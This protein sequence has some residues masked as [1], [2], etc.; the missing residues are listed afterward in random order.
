MT[1]HLE[2]L[3]DILSALQNTILLQSTLL[4]KAEERERNMQAEFSRRMQSMEKEV[5][6][7]QSGIHDLVNGASFRI[8]DEAGKA[9]RPLVARY[10]FEAS[11]ATTKLRMASRIVWLWFGGALSILLLTF[12]VGWISVNHDQREIAAASDKLQRYENAVTIVDAFY[13]SD[14]VVCGDPGAPRICANIDPNGARAI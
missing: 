6:L 14:A 12:A 3:P 4:A 10:D 11:A 5:R 8:I 13:A 1:S 7:A 2:E 9:F